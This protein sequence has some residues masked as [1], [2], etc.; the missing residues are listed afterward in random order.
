MAIAVIAGLTFA[1]F[2]TLILVPVMFSL[3]DDAED[4]LSRAFTYPAAQALA[5]AKRA[6]ARERPE[7][8]PEPAGLAKESTPHPAT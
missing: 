7:P 1:T 6:E 4:W 5:K 8:V 3:I 2:L